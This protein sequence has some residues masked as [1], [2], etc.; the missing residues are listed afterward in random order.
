MVKLHKIIRKKQVAKPR[1]P[2]MPIPGYLK[3]KIIIPSELIS[4]PSYLKPVVRSLV[5]AMGNVTRRTKTM[6]YPNEVRYLGKYIN[7]ESI[8]ATHF[9]KEGKYVKFLRPKVV[10]IHSSFRVSLNRAVKRK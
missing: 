8:L 9:I 7:K 5:E 3:R 6:D 2:I 1:V 4:A 10:Q